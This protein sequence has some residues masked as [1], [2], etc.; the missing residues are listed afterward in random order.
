L[1]IYQAEAARILKVSTVTLSRWECDK[2]YPTWP[3]QPALIE[4]LGYDPFTHPALGRP[5]GNETPGVA[6]LSSEPSAD[7]GQRIKKRRL[8]LKKTRKQMAKELGISVKSLWGWETE[9]HQPRAL[10]RTQ[11]V[12][13]L[14]FKPKT[15]NP[16]GK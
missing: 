8:E 10:L 9:R 16:A 12:E 5:K 15:A 13:F 6:F 7:I 14:G 1:K 3:H 2:V 4:Y 11:I